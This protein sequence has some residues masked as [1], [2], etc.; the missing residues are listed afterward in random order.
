MM[1]LE[2]LCYLHMCY[3]L[4]CC[5]CCL[6]ENNHISKYK[7]FLLENKDPV[8]VNVTTNLF[9]LPY[10]TDMS[11]HPSYICTNHES[12]VLVAEDIVVRIIGNT[13]NPLQVES[14]GASK[15]FSERKY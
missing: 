10:A 5:C 1:I 7:R 12:D 13:S 4:E 8:K 11:S 3:C 14:F 6:N 15:N 2:S 9:S